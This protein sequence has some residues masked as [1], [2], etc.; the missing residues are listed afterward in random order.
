M[1]YRPEGGGIHKGDR[2]LEWNSLQYFIPGCSGEGGRK[3]GR[4][5]CGSPLKLLEGKVGSGKK[6]RLG[7]VLVSEPVGKMVPRS[8]K[9]QT[10]TCR[11]GGDTASSLPFHWEE[12]KGSPGSFSTR[13]P[14]RPVAPTNWTCKFTSLRHRLASP[15]LSYVCTTGDEARASRRHAGGVKVTKARALARIACSSAL[16]VSLGSTGLLRLD[17]LFYS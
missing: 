13:V 16:I 1:E 12:R 5:A 17:H 9:Q 6:T 3:G 10:E 15:I 14:A 8:G 2:E 11:G 7:V 4:S